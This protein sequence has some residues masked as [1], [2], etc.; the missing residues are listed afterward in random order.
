MEG[1]KLLH[2]QRL[3][4]LILGSSAGTLQPPQKDFGRTGIGNGSFTQTTFDVG[5]ARG[6]AVTT[7]CPALATQPCGLARLLW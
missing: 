4:A 1:L 6:R 3:H 5:I 7:A 2:R